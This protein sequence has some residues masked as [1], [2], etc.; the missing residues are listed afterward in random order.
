MAKKKNNLEWAIMNVL[1]SIYDS[2]VGDTDADRVDNA[3]NGIGYIDIQGLVVAR[4]SVTNAPII[5]FT[6]KQWVYYMGMYECIA[7]AQSIT[8]QWPGDDDHE[9]VMIASVANKLVNGLNKSNQ[10]RIKRLQIANEEMLAKFG[11]DNHK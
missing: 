4:D 9:D 5:L 7:E 8:D 1:D 3:N 2:D 6:A 11:P 10:K